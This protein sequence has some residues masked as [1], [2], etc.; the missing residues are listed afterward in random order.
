MLMAVSKLRKAS[1]RC[2]IGKKMTVSEQLLSYNQLIILQNMV[3]SLVFDKTVKHCE[4]VTD[5][6]ITYSK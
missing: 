1:N 3:F 4:N 2:E 6:L 5:V